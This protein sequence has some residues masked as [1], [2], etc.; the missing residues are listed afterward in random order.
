MDSIIDPLALAAETGKRV[1]EAGGETYRAEEIVVSLCRAWNLAEAECFATPTGL[2]AS[3]SD[4]EGASR[5]VVRRITRRSVDLYRI[6]RI[7]EEI[8]KLRT[9]GSEPAVFKTT[10]EA[11]VAEKPYS[12]GAILVAAGASASFFTLLFGGEPRDAACAFVVG[13]AIKATAAFSL[14]NRFPDFIVNIAGGA[15]AAALSSAA[16]SFGFAANLDKT[17]IG[18]IMLLVPGLATVN[19]IRDTIA[20]DLVAGVARLADAFMAAAAI[21]IGAGFAL[22]AAAL[23]S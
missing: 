4:G 19:A 2:M 16:V 10:L 9:L 22:S 13:F 12:S 8:G 23:L 11:L 15:V 21:S 20:G 1:L 17:V 6:A 18:S 3:V 7:S 5:S 14:K